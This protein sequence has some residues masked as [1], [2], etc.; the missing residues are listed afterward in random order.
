MFSHKMMFVS[1]KFTITGSQMNKIT[2]LVLGTSILISSMFSSL[3][4]AQTSCPDGQ[5]F[6]SD[7]GACQT[8][9][10]P[11]GMDDGTDPRL[12]RFLTPDNQSVF[13]TGTEVAPTGRSS[14]SR[15]Q[16][17]PLDLTIVLDVTSS[18]NRPTSVVNPDEMIGGPDRGD[19]FYSV[20]DMARSVLGDLSKV[21]PYNTVLTG[22]TFG[23][24]VNILSEKLLD[25]NF[26]LIP[27]NNDATD[28]AA[29]QNML[30]TTPANGRAEEYDQL[31]R[32]ISGFYNDTVTLT[33]LDLHDREL[34]ILT[35][36]LNSGAPISPFVLNTFGGYAD[37]TI[38]SLPG[39]RPQGVRFQ[40]DLA[41]TIGA[42]FLDFTQDQD[43]FLDLF[44]TST[45]LFSGVE[46]VEITD[47]DGDSYFAAL[48]PF[49]D[50]ELDYFALK[51]GA[52]IFTATSRFSDGSTA[53]DQL[54]LTGLTPAVAAVPLPTS[55]VLLVMC[56]SMLAWCRRRT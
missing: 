13:A 4:V 41:T 11:P 55:G 25:A 27:D 47:P 28:K 3:A 51:E 32:T 22:M 35:D 54:N 26:D 48:N 53:V 44:K 15:V 45:S 20:I 2:K 5:V 36:G 33:P 24:G 14:L 1:Y 10:N 17:L 43:S 34:L 42:R 7:T 50:F 52:N 46:S 19:G 16:D 23:N 29:I 18:M 21:L 49:G 39:T 30:L 40:S 9:P 8:D 31:F 12:L 37:A 6:N 38:L 56:I